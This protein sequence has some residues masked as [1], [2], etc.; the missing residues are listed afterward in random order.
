MTFEE[1][2][3]QKL[4]IVADIRS[5][6][7][8]TPA[9]KIVAY[10]GEESREIQEAVDVS[11]LWRNDFNDGIFQSTHIWVELTVEGAAW[12]LGGYLHHILSIVP[13]IDDTDR[14]DK[15]SPFFTDFAVQTACSVL[16]DNRS[17][18]CCTIETTRTLQQTDPALFQLTA[19]AVAWM[20]M[21]DELFAGK[22]F[23]FEP[24]DVLQLR[25]NWELSSAS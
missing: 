12:L 22:L 13:V 24:D 8:R 3:R 20:L 25:G 23:Y 2:L 17:I 1:L 15:F 6:W 7:P 5:Y 9:G 19:R 10:A 21:A 18:S 14:M 11:D 16:R 4:E